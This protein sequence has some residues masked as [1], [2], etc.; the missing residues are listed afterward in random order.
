QKWA[1]I[2]KRIAGPIR[3]K[4]IIIEPALKIIRIS[5][6]VLFS[7]KKGLQTVENTI[8]CQNE[9]HYRGLLVDN[10]YATQVPYQKP[11]HSVYA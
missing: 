3:I 4:Y 2:P 9:P 8:D 6:Y 5:L 7:K 11:I 10:D 1:S